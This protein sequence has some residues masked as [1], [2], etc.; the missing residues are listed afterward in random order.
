MKNTIEKNSWKKWKPKKDKIR[1][2]FI[3][4]K[5]NN[6]SKNIF[7]K[8]NNL[9]NKKNNSKDLLDMYIKGYEKGIIDGYQKGYQIGWIQGYSSFENFFLK[10]FKSCIYF[11]YI[12]FLNQFKYAIKIFNNNFSKRLTKIIFCISKILIDD[13]YL[14]KKKFIITRIKKLTLNPKYILKKLQLH[15]H[16]NNYNFIKKE[17]GKLFYKYNWTIVLNDTLD[18]N[19]YRIF[20]DDGEIDATIKSFWNQIKNA[21]NLLD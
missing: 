10:N 4:K 2:N 11:Q 14:K 12:D 21:T 19:S 13:I 16:P 9:Y 6:I 3:N 20:T 5:K 15:I 8:E 1:F 18:I 17:F 7:F